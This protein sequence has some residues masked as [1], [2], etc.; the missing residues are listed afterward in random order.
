M[1]APLLQH[2]DEAVCHMQLR[3][4][5]AFAPLWAR[6]EDEGMPAGMSDALKSHGE[7]SVARAHEG[8]E[9]LLAGRDWM[10]GGQRSVADAYFM[11]VAR[12]LDYHEVFPRERY[13]RVHALYERLRGDPALRVAEAAEAGQPLPAGAAA[14]AVLSLDEALALLPSTAA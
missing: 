5:G 13:P 3:F 2:V 12:W 8:L 14:T 1:S 10:A 4:Y 6:M 11:G 7:A 9:R